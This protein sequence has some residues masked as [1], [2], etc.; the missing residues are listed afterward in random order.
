MPWT[1]TITDVDDF[2]PDDLR[3]TITISDGTRTARTIETTLPAASTPA[4]AARLLQEIVDDHAP[5]LA[6]ADDARPRLLGLSA[7]QKPNAADGAL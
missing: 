2:G 4:D 3:L 7:T 1:A 5:A 6:R